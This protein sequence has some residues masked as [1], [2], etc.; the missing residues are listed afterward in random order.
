MVMAFDPQ[1]HV[2]L[3]CSL[4]YKN[5]C[6][7]CLGDAAVSKGESELGPYK[8]PTV[9]HPDSMKLFSRSDLCHFVLGGMSCPNKIPRAAVLCPRE[10]ERGRE[11]FFLVCVCVYFNMLVC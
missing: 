9:R 1:D 2:A 8:G 5:M 11:C 6:I 7:S 4:V 10:R 3:S